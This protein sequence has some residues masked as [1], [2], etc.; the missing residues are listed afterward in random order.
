MESGIQHK[1]SRIALAIGIQYQE[2]GIP[3]VESRIQHCLGFPYMGQKLLYNCKLHLFLLILGCDLILGHTVDRDLLLL[4]QHEVRDL[5]KECNAIKSQM[6]EHHE[7][8]GAMEEKLQEAAADNRSKEVEKVLER[9]LSFEAQI[10][11]RIQTLEDEVDQ[12]KQTQT[13]T[14]HEVALLKHS[15]TK[16]ADEVELLKHSHTKTADE[17]EL[18]KHSHAE[19]AAKVDQLGQEIGQEL[20]SLITQNEK[21]GKLSL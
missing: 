20:K 18:L 16:T 8:L 5:V 19:T 10:S 14:T 6:I 1:K 4:I 13:V 7:R 3:D 12:L 21:I 11:I 9:L 17:V 2:S 15:H